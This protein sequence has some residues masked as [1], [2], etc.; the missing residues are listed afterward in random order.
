MFRANVS[1]QL[2]NYMIIIR[3][4]NVNIPRFEDL[5]LTDIYKEV[6]TKSQG[7]ILVT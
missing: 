3:L 5:N 6:V 4:L 7:L 2:S 1:F